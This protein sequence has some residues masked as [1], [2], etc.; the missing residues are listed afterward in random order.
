MITWYCKKLTVAGTQLSPSV[1]IGGRDTVVRHVQ[2]SATVQT[3]VNY[4]CQPQEQP[5]GDVKPMKLVV[6]YLT[7]AA[8]KLPSAGDDAGSRVRHS[9]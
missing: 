4:H 3:P 7:Q 5:I 8:I 2:W 9:L 1:S 6:Q